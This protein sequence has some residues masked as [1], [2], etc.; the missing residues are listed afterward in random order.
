[1]R[2]INRCATI[3]YQNP[4]YLTPLLTD[5]SFQFIMAVNVHTLVVLADKL[6]MFRMYMLC[7][8]SGLESSTLM[9]AAYSLETSVSTYKATWRYKTRDHK[10]KLNYH[11]VCDIIRSDINSKHWKLY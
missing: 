8:S 7:P 2:I 10:T 3:Y 11:S 5:V 4:S 9:E 6:P 1:M